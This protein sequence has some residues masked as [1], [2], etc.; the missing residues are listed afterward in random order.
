LLLLTSDHDGEALSAARAL[1]KTLQ[2]SGHDLHWLADRPF[3]PQN[4]AHKATSGDPDCAAMDW[5]Q[6]ALWRL[7]T[8]P[9]DLLT[10]HQHSF[11]C[12]VAGYDRPP[13]EKQSDF[14]RDLVAKVKKVVQP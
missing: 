10:E 7:E 1:V 11:L 2:K 3:S 6:L 14:L 13:S 4:G 5:R 8:A 9:A 12:N